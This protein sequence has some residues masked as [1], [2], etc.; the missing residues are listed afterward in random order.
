MAHPTK[1]LP[2]TSQTK[3][4]LTLTLNPKTKLTQHWS[5]A[6]TL[7]NPNICA[8]IVDTHNKVFAD[9]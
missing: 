6:L 7:L 4:T 2:L 5:M 9:L 1:L 8:H 3:L